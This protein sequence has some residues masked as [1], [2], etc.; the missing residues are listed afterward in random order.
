MATMVLKSSATQRRSCAIWWR[1]LSPNLPTVTDTG[2]PATARLTGRRFVRRAACLAVLAWLLTPVAS[3]AA[4]RTSLPLGHAGR[5]ITDPG[6]R[7]VIMHGTNMVYKVPPYY[8]GAAG[9]GAGDAAF[10]RSIGFNVV[11]VGVIFQA[12][13]PLP[14]VFDQAYLNHIARTA[15]ILA[16]HGIV[17]ILDFHQDQ[18]NQKFQGEGFPS[19]AVQDGGLPN[20]KLG[21]PHN[22]EGNPA[23]QRAFENFWADMPG[24]GGVGLQERYVAAWAR[25]A[26]RFRGNRSVLGYEI[27]NEPFPGS[28]YTSC[29]GPAGC[30]S[31]DAELTSLER[32]VD[33][34]IRRIDPHTLVFQEPY[35]TFNFGYADHVGPLRDRHAVFAWHDYCL[36]GTTCSSNRTTM[37]NAAAYVARTGEATFMTEYGATSSASA[38]DQMVSLADQFMVPWTEWAYCECRDPTG[39][40]DE[41]MVVNPRRPKRGANLVRSILHALVEPYPQVVAGTPESWAF[42]RS[43]KTFRLRYSTARAGAAGRFLAGAITRIAVPRLVYGRG[44]S[45]RVAGGAIVSR[46]SVG[47]LEVTSCRGASTVR[48]TLAPAGRS[49]ASCVLARRAGGPAPRFTG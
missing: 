44:Y 11:R 33:R 36:V 12:L 40:P 49:R 32:K 9:F 31:S 23:L 24:P 5:W 46:R 42:N 16:R 1:F 41:G 29:A 26:R 25:V 13:E 17:S 19:W 22:Y 28:D 2:G 21:F 38:L 47:A 10:L 45:V 20:P 15:H 48:V 30:P 37:E 7:V 35:V 6:G 34:K 39:S 3:A 4:A 14:G 27:M 8:P 43:T 18:Y